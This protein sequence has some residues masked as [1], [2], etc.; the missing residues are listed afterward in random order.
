MVRITTRVRGERRTAWWV[1]SRPPSPGIARSATSTSGVRRSTIS[2]AVRPSP[3]SPTTWRSDSARRRARTPWRTI[4]WS[5]ARTMRTGSIR[6]TVL[7]GESP[8]GRPRAWSRVPAPTRPAGGPPPAEPAPACRRGPRAPGRCRRGLEAAATILDP[9]LEALGP[10]LEAHLDLRDPRVTGHVRQGLLH[11]AEGRCL[12]GRGETT[13]GLAAAKLH[14]HPGLGLVSLEVPEERGQEPEVV[15]RRW[16]EVHGETAHPVE[17]LPQDRLHFR[18]G[19]IRPPL[20]AKPQA[21]EDLPHLVVQLAGERAS[22][23]LLHLHEPPGEALEALVTLAQLL[24]G[25]FGVCP[26][27]AL[28][29]EQPIPLALGESERGSRSS[30]RQAQARSQPGQGGSRVQEVR[31]PRGRERLRQ[32]VLALHRG[33]QE[34]RVIRPTLLEPE[35][36]GRVRGQRVETDLLHREKS[37]VDL[38]GLRPEADTHPAKTRACR[39]CPHDLGTVDVL[40]LESNPE[41]RPRPAESFLALLHDAEGGRLHPGGKTTRGVAAAELHAHPGLGLVS[42]EVPEERRQE[43]ELV[44]RR[45]PEVHGEA[46]DPVEQLPEDRLHLRRGPVRPPL[47]PEP[48]AGEDLPHLVVQ[49]PGERASLGLLHLHEPAGEALE[50]LVALAQLLQGGLGVFPRLA[51]ALEQPIPLALGEAGRGSRSS[52]RQAQAGSQPRQGGARVQEVGVP[53]GRERLRQSSARPPPGRTGA[54]RAPANASSA[55]EAGPGPGAAG[56]GRSPGRRAGAR[57][58]GSPCRSRPLPPPRHPAAPAAAPSGSARGGP[59]QG[60][61]GERATGRG[62]CSRYRS[63]RATASR[64]QECFEGSNSRGQSLALQTGPGRRRGRPS[65]G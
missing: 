4:S 8:E 58:T 45:R 19:L 50:A 1:S 16:P 35:R 22:L 55:R 6:S 14:A 24:Q 51:L 29:L 15:E 26:R 25:G 27:P 64:D 49:L 52:Q 40:G 17:E 31:V 63:A 56:G 2:S 7:P 5:S 9:Q 39:R 37:L 30:P 43:P 28:A 23:G 18:R 47:Q 62:S 33:E 21:G 54:A 53:R 3:A 41:L 65:H 13:L 60:R 20:Q 32:S 59:L 61:R 38:S 44:E 36:Q 48:Q 34:Q 42:P 10:S 11:D 57:A 46:A 12:H